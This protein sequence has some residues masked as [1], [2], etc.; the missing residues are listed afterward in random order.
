MVCRVWGAIFV[1]FLFVCAVSLPF[2]L[3]HNSVFTS[4]LLGEYRVPIVIYAGR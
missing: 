4:L 2:R 3:G 1:F